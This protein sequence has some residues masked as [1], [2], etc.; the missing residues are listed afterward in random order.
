MA[1]SAFPQSAQQMLPAPPQAGASPLRPE[2]VPHAANRRPARDAGIAE[3]VAT[4]GLLRFLIL[5]T[6]ICGLTCVYVWQANTISSIRYET[7]TVTTEIQTLER[8]NVG[9]ML[10]VASLDT[11]EYIEAKSNEAGMVAGQTPLRVQLPG[12]G[13]RQAAAS[14]DAEYD[15]PIKQMAAWLPGSSTIWSQPK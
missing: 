11:P 12:P 2:P 3:P 8:Q 6:V 9:L 15:F 5:L 14:P 7:Q 13:A 10:E 1:Y 4:S